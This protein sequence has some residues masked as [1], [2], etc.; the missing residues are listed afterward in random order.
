MGSVWIKFSNYKRF[1]KMPNPVFFAKP[2]PRI[3]EYF[4]IVFQDLGLGIIFMSGYIGWDMSS[5]KRYMKIPLYFSI[6]LCNN[7]S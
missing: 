3:I 7:N 2:S 1:C 5:N 4:P 6:L